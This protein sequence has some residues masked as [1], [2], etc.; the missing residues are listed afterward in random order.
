MSSS[1]SLSSESEYFSTE[2]FTD[3]DDSDLEELNQEVCNLKLQPYQFEPLKKNNT[4]LEDLLENDYVEDQGDEESPFPIIAEEI[5]A[6]GTCLGVNVDFAKRNQ[7][8]LTVC[9][10][11]RL[12][13]YLMSYFQVSKAEKQLPV[14]K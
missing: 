3:Y 11:E 2:D 5:E 4:N 9:V 6:L 12:Q 10:A 13:L 1:S 7:E 8:K 14:F